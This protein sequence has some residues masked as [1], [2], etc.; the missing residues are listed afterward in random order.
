M[1]S[2]PRVVVVVC[3]DDNGDDKDNSCT[4]DVLPVIGVTG[5]C[6]FHKFGNS[7][8]TYLKTLESP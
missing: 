2:K 3:V 7:F 1:F 5:F 8:L 6:G 4:S